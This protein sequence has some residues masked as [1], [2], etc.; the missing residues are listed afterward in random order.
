MSEEYDLKK[1]EQGIGQLYPILVAKDGGIIDGLHRDKA[2]KNWK[3]LK[4]EHIDT[5]EKKLLAR[6]I[7][8]FHRRQITREEKEEWINGL[9]RIY[10]KQGLKVDIHNENEIVNRIAET[11]GLE[12]STVL[13]HLKSEYKQEPTTIR[14]PIIPASQRIEHE[15]G[16][17]YV[18]RHREEVLAEEKPK[19]E[20][21]IKRELLESPEF[22][23]EAIEKAP[24]LV[25]SLSQKTIERAKKLVEPKEMVVQEGITYTIGEY[26]CPHCKKHYLIRCDGKHDWVE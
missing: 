15:L 26:E 3:R 7:A 16:A 8:N 21:Q 6:L 23:R 1:S 11:T 13:R 2:D 4:L 17:D 9:A 25:P 24:E 18:E 10:K 14:E 19:L 5:E 22:I 12:R 20:K